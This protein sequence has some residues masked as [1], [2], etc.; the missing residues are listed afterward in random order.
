[1]IAPSSDFRIGAL[2]DSTRESWERFVDAHPEATFFHRAGWKRVL[3]RSFGHRAYFLYAAKGDTIHGV[4]PLLHTKSALFGNHLSS[5]AFCVY[6]GPAADSEAALQALDDAAVKLAEKLGV[7]HLEYRHRTPREVSG[8]VA[9]S[10]LYA[11]FRK[12]IHAD[13]EKN[14]LEIPRKQR[15]MVRKG[16]KFELASTIEA[17]PARLYPVYA[18]SVRNL[19]TP[20]FARR[21]FDTLK[22]EFGDACEILMVTHQGRDVAGVMNFYFRDEVLPY[23]GGGTAAARGLAANDFMYWEVMRR[24]CERGIRLFD[25]GRSKRGTGAFD[26]KKNWGFTP[27]PLHYLYRLHKSADLPDLNPLNPKFRLFIET[28]KRLPLP[29]ANAIGPYIVRSLG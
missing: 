17:E 25:F 12:P 22:Q 23:Y 20:V 5:T 7:G 1:M 16:I 6:G 2:D 19:G 29:V 24:A 28:W 18:E 26:F 11:T 3:E 15:A 13:P 4:L 9:K 8:W 21:Y 14:M 10:E 27:E